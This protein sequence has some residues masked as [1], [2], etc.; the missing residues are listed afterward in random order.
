M[1]YV[2]S[3]LR[4]VGFWFLLALCAASPARADGITPGEV[5]SGS[6]LMK[7][8]DGYVTATLLNT[9]VTITVNGLVARVS[10]MQEFSNE[11]SEW[12]E[13]IYVF[14]LPDKAAVD[15]MRLYIGDR[16]IEGEIREKAEAR[17]A[18]EAA[19]RDG[20]KTSLVEQQRANLFTT[21]VAN[22]APGETVI[23][24]IEYLEDVRFDNGTYSLRFPMTLT[25]RYIPG[26]ALP[27]RKGNGWSPDT[28]LVE[29]ASLVTPPMVSASRGHKVSISASVNAGMALDII[30][31]RYHP[32]SIGEAAGRYLVTLAGS[33]VPMDHDF[34]LLW[35]PVPASAPRAMVFTE[36]VD[37]QP[38]YLLLV[39]PPETNAAASAPVPREMIFIIDTSGSMHGVSIE[40]ARQALRRALDALRPGDRFNV[41]EFNSHTR[42]LFPASVAATANNVGAAQA[43]VRQL[44]ANGGTE[45][46]PA[47]RFALASQPA[48]S[49]LR[50][51]VFITDGA[52]GNEEGLFQVIEQQLNGARLFTVGIG[53]APN[54]WF[55]RKAAEAGRGT[56]TIISALHEVGEKMDRLFQKLENPQV[57]NI[58]LQWP[59][60]TLVDSYP[61]VVPDLYLGEPV[62]VRARASTR[63]RPGDTVRIAGDSPAG[64][65][66]ADLPLD[67]SEDSPGV[68]ALWA[69]ARIADLLDRLR[70]GANADEIRQSVV[71]TA[72]RHH[73]VS[74]FTSLVAVDKTPARPAGDPLASEQVPNRMPYGQSASAIFGFPAT[75]TSA[76][77]QRLV[78]GILVL[79][80]LLLLLLWP[81][82]RPKRHGLAA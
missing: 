22:I 72:L 68:G 49:H 39:V 25:P 9:D 17:K 55:M 70:R 80:A 76:P 62:T 18:Y 44:D 71:G 69:R 24:E 32:V 15:R 3:A 65:W 26:Q 34:E 42:P 82:A 74:K 5:Q 52:V 57:T 51:V 77:L 20:R 46:Y 12:V 28:D 40:Q 30:A 81:Q 21:S 45:M 60:G 56:F 10:V 27:D 64:A 7:M 75:A 58:E 23:V 13:G 43:F 14:P 29:D 73:L 67:T 47:L 19:K 1:R 33:R 38:H 36:T 35:R 41:V 2:I 66:S 79:A 63:F 59:G 8:A 6:L 50:Q 16:F 11:G 54:S 48:E 31:S 78:G 4:I 61:A 37:D 53:S